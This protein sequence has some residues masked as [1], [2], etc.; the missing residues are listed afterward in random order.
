MKKYD[1]NFVLDMF[2]NDWTKNADSALP[3]IQ[4]LTDDQLKD[5]RAWINQHEKEIN[6]LKEIF[7]EQANYYSA[8]M[9]GAVE[10][11]INGDGQLMRLSQIMWDERGRRIYCANLAFD[12]YL[13]A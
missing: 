5:L 7:M 9:Q 4:D 1:D 11:L 12:E 6:K 3:V 2:L 8:I 10:S 13:A